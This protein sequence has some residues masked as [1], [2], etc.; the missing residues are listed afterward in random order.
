[1]PVA[2][3]AKAV[4]WTDPRVRRFIGE[5][6][7]RLVSSVRLVLLILSAYLKGSLYCSCTGRAASAPHAPV[8]RSSPIA[9]STRLRPRTAPTHSP[10]TRPPAAGRAEPGVRP[11]RNVQRRRT[12]TPQGSARQARSR[13]PQAR[14]GPLRRRGPTR[15]PQDRAGPH[16]A[17]VDVITNQLD[18]LRGR[19]PHGCLLEQVWG[20][21]PP[22]NTAEQKRLALSASTSLPSVE[23]S[24][25]YSNIKAQVSSLETLRMKLPDL[26]TPPRPTPC[27]APGGF[28]VRCLGR[29]NGAS[30]FTWIRTR[31][32]I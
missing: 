23:A 4:G 7:G 12:Q 24:R 9:S 1:M 30:L 13:T 18:S 16:R 5:P 14:P 17:N 10:P 11:A 32:I 6:D 22:E 21:A 29:T 8:P 20:V 31:I 2:Q 15:P 26:A 25:P 28:S 3:A 19:G 27:E